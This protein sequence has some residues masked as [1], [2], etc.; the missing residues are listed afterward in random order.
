M[1]K[2][3]I[4]SNLQ[5]ATTQLDEKQNL[6]NN[7][8]LNSSIN[9]SSLKDNMASSETKKSNILLIILILLALSAGTATGYGASRLTKG[10][11]GLLGSKGQ[12]TLEVAPEDKN[13]IKNGDV[14]GS[15]SSI[16]KDSAQGFVVVNDKFEVGSHL[17]LRAGGE[18]QTVTLVSSVTDL[19]QFEGMEVKV[20][21]ETMKSNK[22]SWF[23]DVGKVEVINVQGVNPNQEESSEVEEKSNTTSQSLEE[24]E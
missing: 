6:D 21:G 12:K 8:S 18:S 2:L 24:A 23:M 20:S 4:D 7:N 19:A 11:T 5:M 17:L 14:F 15:D 9:S 1:K 10:K 16:F 13:A 22:V 3:E